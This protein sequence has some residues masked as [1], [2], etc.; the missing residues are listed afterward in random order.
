MVGEDLAGA[1]TL[2]SGKKTR[3]T[4]RAVSQ[5]VGGDEGEKLVEIPIGENRLRLVVDTKGGRRKG[6]EVGG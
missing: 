2:C 3:K 4:Q 6:Y 5:N 1:L